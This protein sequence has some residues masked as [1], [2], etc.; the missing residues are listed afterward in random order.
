M[1]LVLIVVV[2]AH[3]HH[4][5][6]FLEGEHVV[7]VLVKGSNDEVAT[8]HADVVI[9][10]GVNVFD[11]VFQFLEGEAAAVV[12]IGFVEHGH[13]HLHHVA[14]K[15]FFE[16]GVFVFVVVIVIVRGLVFVVL[17]LFV[18]VLVVIV[19]VHVPCHPELV[20]GKAAVVVCIEF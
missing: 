14:F 9:F 7:A 5:G 10:H 16:G 8:R 17:A 1:G 12:S 11:E 2:M 4:F 18:V 15:G 13:Q 6:E 20:P 3:A 19:V